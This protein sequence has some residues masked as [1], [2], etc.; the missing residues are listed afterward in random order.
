[1][2]QVVISDALYARLEAM[3]RQRGFNSIEELLEDWQTREEALEQRRAAVSRIDALREQLFATYGE[4]PDSAP[5]IRED[6][7]R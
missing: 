5:L 6:R 3:T 7:A 4:M 2:T 1:V